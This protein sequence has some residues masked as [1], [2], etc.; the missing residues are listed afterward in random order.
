MLLL[1]LL[2]LCPLTPRRTLSVPPFFPDRKVANF[3]LKIKYRLFFASNNSATVIDVNVS[4]HALSAVVSFLYL[5][6]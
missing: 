6:D 4:N 5:I 2:T 3:L 1:N